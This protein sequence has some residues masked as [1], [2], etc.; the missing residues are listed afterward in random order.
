VME[1]MLSPLQFFH[2]SPK[3]EPKAPN[4]AELARH[5]KFAGTPDFMSPELVGASSTYTEA[6][7][8]WATGLVVYFLCVGKMMY[9]HLSGS[10]QEEAVTRGVVYV[11]DVP[12]SG[13]QALIRD[14]MAKNANERLPAGVALHHAWLRDVS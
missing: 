14:L 9:G 10:E 13:A 1:S 4:R 3:A 2:E 12:Y 5:S 11:Q 7:D 8:L 6:V